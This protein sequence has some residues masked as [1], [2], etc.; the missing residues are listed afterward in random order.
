MNILA[1][2]FIDWSFVPEEEFPGETGMVRS[3]TALLNGLRVRQV[4]YLAGYR[5]EGWCGQGHFIYC[6]EGNP[7]I[8]FED[9][10]ELT[11]EP[12]QTLLLPDDP[13]NRHRVAAKEDCRL[14]IVDSR[15]EEGSD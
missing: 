10:S 13:G 5:A 1:P 8:A 12:T 4:T 6:L 11:L 15:P 9:G 3:R 7:S 14:L 2:A